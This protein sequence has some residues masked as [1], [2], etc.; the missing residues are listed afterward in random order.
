MPIQTACPKCAKTYNL[1]DAMKGKNVKCK[2]CASIFLVGAAPAAKTLAPTK[3]APTI[4]PVPAPAN[5]SPA[6]KPAPAPRQSSPAAKGAAG[7]AKT[8]Q[9]NMPAKPP[10]EDIEEVLPADDEA[11]EVLAADDGDDFDDRPAGNPNQPKKK[12]RTMLWVLLGGGGAFAFLVLIGCMGGLYFAF[13]SGFGRK[14]DQESFSRLRKGMTESE[15][16]AI[17]GGKPTSSSNVMGVNA[18]AWQQG[19]NKIIVMYDDAGK[20]SGGSGVFKDGKVTTTLMNFKTDAVAQNPPPPP[21]SP[22]PANPPPNNPPPRGNPPPQLP[23]QLPPQPPPPPQTIVTKGPSKK[24]T[25]KT[26]NA[27]QVGMTGPQTRDLLPTLSS[28]TEL[29]N[30]KAPL[31]TPNGQKAMIMEEYRNGKGY[32]RIWSDKS[33][34]V[35]D[36]EMADLPEQ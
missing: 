19:D 29:G 32:L 18:A 34:V 22:P 1:A 10:D 35:V 21:Q 27:I 3:T 20:A 11:A 9:M 30:D 13:G 14:V 36:K 23:P 12:S 16:N 7:S 33:G 6:L 17:L 2:N 31:K 5:N 25:Q 8:M 28:K 15:V 26:F 24:V 4:K